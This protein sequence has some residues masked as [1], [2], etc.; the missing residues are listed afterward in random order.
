MQIGFIGILLANVSSFAR[1]LMTVHRSIQTHG[2]IKLDQQ[3]AGD[4]ACAAASVIG[5]T[6]TTIL[7]TAAM[8]EGFFMIISPREHFI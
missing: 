1:S 8:S 6:A 7:S 4:V 3:H 2:P 5:P